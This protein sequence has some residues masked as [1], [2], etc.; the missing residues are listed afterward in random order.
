MA[1]SNER[2][3]ESIQ[4][5]ALTFGVVEKRESD[6][7]NSFARQEIEAD[8][9]RLEAQDALSAEMNY[10]ERMQAI[11]F[12][13]VHIV[14]RIEITLAHDGE[15]QSLLELKARAESLT[16][17]LEAVDERLFR[18]LR[19][20]IASGRVDRAGLMS[21]LDNCSRSIQTESRSN[22]GY[23]ARDEFV[24]SLIRTSIQPRETIRK[25]PEM[26]S[27]QPTPVRIVT[28]LIEIA[29]I[30]ESDVFCDVGAG[31]GQVTILVNLLTGAR[32]IGIEI[33]ERYCEIAAKRMAQEVF[34]LA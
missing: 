23:D 28:R 7:L 4:L 34:D 1:R 20:D 19:A 17:R 30:S 3:Q 18:R 29:N 21:W 8:L 32:A 11:E 2:V 27:Y 12:V 22:V 26:I 25:E 9:T 6:N 31:L 15:S 10:V 14:E 24:S 16:G 5:D 13:Q 33:E